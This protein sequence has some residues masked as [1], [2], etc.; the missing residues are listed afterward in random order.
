VSEPVRLPE[1]SFGCGHRAFNELRREV[2]DLLRSHGADALVDDAVVIITELANNAALHAGTPFEVG[3]LLTD[4]VFRIEVAD[5]S[6]LR[7]PTSEAEE[8]LG[9]HLVG[10]LADRWGV[11]EDGGGKVVWAELNR[12]D[13]RG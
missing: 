12:M 7:P 2:A 9:L 8:G 3:G 1:L 5:G 6:P 13:R 10:R 11:S 4:H